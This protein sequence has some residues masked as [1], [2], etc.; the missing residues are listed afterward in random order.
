MLEVNSLN[1]CTKGET[2]KMCVCTSVCV[3]C[4]YLYLFMHMCILLSV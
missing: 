4:L 2:Q 1:R 3:V